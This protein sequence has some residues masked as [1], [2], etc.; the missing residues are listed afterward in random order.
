MRRI[1][2]VK[3]ANHGRGVEGTTIQLILWQPSDGG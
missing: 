2:Q 1:V 3:Q